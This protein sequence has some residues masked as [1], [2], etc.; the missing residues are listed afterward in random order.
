MQLTQQILKNLFDYNDGFLYWK[1]GGSGKNIGDKA[2]CL[3]KRKNGDR[4][5][6]GIGLTKYLSPRLIFFWHNG[7]LPEMVDHQDGDE[8]NDKI[9]NLRAASRSQNNSNKKSAKNSTC[10]YLGVRK[11]GNT[12]I[13]QI[14]VNNKTLYL[15]SFKDEDVAALKYNEAAVKYHGNFANINI[16]KNGLIQD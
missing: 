1:K 10:K 14:T 2:G 3:N 16:I 9:D 12:F 11:R 4:Y 6:I 15:G 13:T 7:Y 8:L 5:M